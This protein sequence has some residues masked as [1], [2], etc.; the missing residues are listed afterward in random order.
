[1]TCAPG[2]LPQPAAVS[3]HPACGARLAADEL[4]AHLRHALAHDVDP[5][6]CVRA[7]F[8][9][10]HG[11]AALQAS[12]G[13]DA[14]D[15]LL[16]LLLLGGAPPRAA[17]TLACGVSPSAHAV[18]LARVASA[19]L[20]R[21]A[22]ED[23]G[24]EAGTPVLSWLMARWPSAVGALGAGVA[25][26]LLTALARDEVSTP[27]QWQA[28]AGWALAAGAPRTRLRAAL[29]AAWGSVLWRQSAELEACGA[30]SAPPWH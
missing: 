10:A 25:W 27:G 4:A 19:A 5:A 6:G 22:A 14:L 11:A 9:L 23:G 15:P 29:G 13:V 8:A 1:M 16:D 7:A 30:A 2:S 17:T 28:L 3:A 21:A 20:R 24:R 18:G 26:R 12:G